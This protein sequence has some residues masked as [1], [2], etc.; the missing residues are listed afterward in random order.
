[1]ANI[2]DTQREL[3]VSAI[4]HLIAGDSDTDLEALK[5]IKMLLGRME[6]S[7]KKKFKVED[8]LTEYFELN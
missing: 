6:Y 3:I 4:Q 2:Y 1:M 5:V 8:I 7:Q